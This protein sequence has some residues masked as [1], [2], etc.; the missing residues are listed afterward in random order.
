MRLRIRALLLR[1]TTPEGLYGARIN[2]A[3]GL[4]LIRAGNTKGKSTCIQSILYA[5]GLE[6]MLSARHEVPLTPAVT[7]SIFTDD[8][9]RLS[10]LES[11][12]LLEIENHQGD[13]LTIRRPIAGRNDIKLISVWEGPVLSMQ[14]K[15]LQRRDY[16]VRT[17]G[18]AAR[19]AGF[20][21]RLAAF[22][23]WEL[24]QVP[25]FSGKTVPLYMEAVMPLMFVEQKKGW[26]GTH[27][28]FPGQFA[29]REVGRR[30]VEF[31]LSMDVY[32]LEVNRE[33]TRERASEV[34]TQWKEAVA[35][36]EGLASSLSGAIREV[37][38]EPVAEW[39]PAVLPFPTISVTSQWLPAD[40]ARRT[41]ENELNELEGKLIP[42]VNQVVSA[43]E[44][45]LSQEEERL[46]TIEIGVTRLLEEL[47]LDKA[48]LSEIDE[49]LQAIEEDLR[50]NQ[51][52]LKLRHLGSVQEFDI[53]NDRCPVCHQELRDSLLPQ[54]LERQPMSLE[55]NIN[56]LKEQR[57]IF[58]FMREQALRVIS[59]KDRQV[60]AFRQGANENRSRIRILK[61]T[62]LSRGEEPS[63]AAVE[64]KYRLRD[65]IDKIDRLHKLAESLFSRLEQLSQEWAGIESARAQEPKE[66]LSATDVAKLTDLE[67]SIKEQLSSYQFSS[68]E[69][70]DLSVSR[71]TY[72]L[73][74]EGFDLQFEI[75]ASD[76]VRVLW[77]Y[78][79]GLLE[80]SRD[81]ST[82]HLGLLIADE[83]R[84]Q[85]MAHESMTEFLR[86][87]STAGQFGQQVIVTTSFDESLIRSE[88]KEAPHT[89]LSFEGRILGKLQIP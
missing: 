87:A 48:Q 19:E 29:I 25:T 63:L 27:P 61:E 12:V 88:L 67:S 49:R 86:R 79:L 59:E 22:I 33:L 84:Q 47:E 23:G 18:G 83:P 45:E 21:N 7:E 64:R 36:A 70:D 85:E 44:E 53:I 51:D 34:K 15:G 24:P 17:Q 41:A 40:E 71:G 35:R 31:L 32:R 26:G 3:P 80:V 81:W 46:G 89:L 78:L 14:A 62:L 2:F 75:S 28:R 66:G 20:H 69:P 8:D 5:L 30:A 65:R 39:P 10:V 68:R 57:N 55:E 4:C 16:F 38:R 58:R 76:V 42:Q 60:S 74:H 77:A 9:R 50:Q 73:V 13:I 54:D 72:Q 52:N 43:T 1:V 82:N 56:F 6:G 37:P 11:E